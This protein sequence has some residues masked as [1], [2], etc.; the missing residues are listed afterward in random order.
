MSA[1]NMFSVVPA[2]V[3]AFGFASAAMAQTA[4]A[5]AAP[6]AKPTA[7]AAAATQAATGSTGKSRLMNSQKFITVA[8][9]QASCPTDTVVWSSLTKS[10]SFHLPNSRYY[11]KT[12]H[13]AYVCEQ[14]ALAA[15]YHKARS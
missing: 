1:K 12:K 2:V 5:P 3:L 15:G 13:G 9:A 11:G 10:H 14:A 8:A 4:A 6:I 7:A